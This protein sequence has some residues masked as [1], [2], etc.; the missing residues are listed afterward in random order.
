MNEVCVSD[1]VYDNSINDESDSGD[2][3]HTDCDN[4]D[5]NDIR[6]NGNK[7][8]AITVVTIVTRTIMTEVMVKVTLLIIITK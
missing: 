4:Y 8:T 3:C 2:D 1:N 5:N 6:H 7:R